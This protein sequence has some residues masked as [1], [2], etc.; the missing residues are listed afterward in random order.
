MMIEQAGKSF[1]A[2]VFSGLNPC[3]NGMMIERVHDAK[4]INTYSES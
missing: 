2:P 1:V 4:V 3:S